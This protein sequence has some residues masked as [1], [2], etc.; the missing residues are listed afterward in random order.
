[1]LID[2]AIFKP[3]IQLQYSLISC[4]FVLIIVLFF[5]GVMVSLIRFYSFVWLLVLEVYWFKGR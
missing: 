1:M 3:F 4:F 5:L 2:M